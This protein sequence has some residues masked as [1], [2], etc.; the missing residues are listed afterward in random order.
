MQDDGTNVITVSTIVFKQMTKNNLH[1][2]YGLH[3]SAGFFLFFLK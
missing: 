1:D 2:K 3:E